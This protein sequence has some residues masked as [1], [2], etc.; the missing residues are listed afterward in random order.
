MN[1]SHNKFIGSI[2]SSFNQCI[3]LSF[4]DI[5]NY[6]L[7]GRLPNNLAFQKASLEELSGNKGLCGHLIVLEPCSSSKITYK[8]IKISM[9]FY[10]FGG[11]L[12][13]MV[14]ISLL[15]ALSQKRRNQI[16]QREQTKDLFSIRS[17]D[18]QMTYESII[19]EIEGFNRKN[20]IGN[21]G[22]GRVF[23][24]E[25]PCGQAVVFLEGGSLPERLR[26][27]EKVTELDW[28]KRVNIVKG[29]AYVL[30]YMHHECSP[31]ILHRDI[32]SKNVL[33]DHE[34]RPHLSDFGTA[35]LLRP[36][37]SNWTSFAGTFGYVAPDLAYTMEINESCDTYSSG[38]L[39]LEVILGRHLADLVH[40]VSS[41]SSTSES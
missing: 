12:L 10:I 20:C 34:D 40:T 37:S 21:G 28:I 24:V 29:V 6:Q 14:I 4:V 11:V 25:L 30:S 39:S 31:P 15:F 7:I 9:I 33:L 16:E 8:R 19:I 27:D 36:N 1:L 35:K 2:P 3:S 18:G 23:R 17:F 13:L 26:N 32:S 5:S 41:L 38:V 22:Q